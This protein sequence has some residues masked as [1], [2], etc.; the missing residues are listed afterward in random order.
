M[1]VAELKEAIE[2]LN[3]EERAQLEALLHPYSPDDWDKQMEA[4]FS[5]T[6]DLAW[7]VDEVDEDI[8]AGKLQDMP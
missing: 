8:K 6:G 2:Q 4:D 3:V 1:T 5:S 7:L